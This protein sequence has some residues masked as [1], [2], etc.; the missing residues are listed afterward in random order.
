MT[1]PE[2]FCAVADFQFLLSV[3]AFVCKSV[4]FSLL[5]IIKKCC[6][7]MFHVRIVK[8]RLSE[9]DHF[10]VGPLKRIFFCKMHTHQQLRLM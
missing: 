8:V 10:K 2:S 7:E 5:V 6:N 9:V 1:F 3:V 4:Y